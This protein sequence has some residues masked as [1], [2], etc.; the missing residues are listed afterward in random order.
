MINA[1]L[2]EPTK[3][4]DEGNIF[5]EIYEEL[6]I[7]NCRPK[8]LVLDNQFSKA[9]KSYIQK[10]RVNIQLVEQYDH[11]VNAAEP[12]VKIANITPPQD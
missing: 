9:V 4:M 12:E 10:E 5:K 3:G 7:R 11:R 1:I 8:L 2:I 6:E